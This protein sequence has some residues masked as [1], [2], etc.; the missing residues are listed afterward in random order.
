[1]SSLRTACGPGSGG[2]QFHLGA[3]VVQHA[4]GDRMTFGMVRVQ[5]CFRRPAADLCGQFPAEVECLLKA[6]VEAL[7][8]GGWMDVCRIAGQQ[9]PPDPITFD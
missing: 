7:S 8:A 9:H 6:Q 5:Q 3:G 2:Q 4:L 1:V